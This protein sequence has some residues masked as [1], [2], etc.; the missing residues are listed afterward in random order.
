MLTWQPCWYINLTWFKNKALTVMNFNGNNK[1][2]L[3]GFSDWCCCETLNIRLSDWLISHKRSGRKA[4]FMYSTMC[5]LKTSNIRNVAFVQN[6]S[7][8]ENAL[9]IQSFTVTI[10]KLISPSQLALQ[11]LAEHWGTISMLSLDYRVRE[12]A[13]LEHTLRILWG[14][15]PLKLTLLLHK[16]CWGG[17]G[18]FPGYTR[19]YILTPLLQTF[20][21][22]ML[23]Q[24]LLHTVHTLTLLCPR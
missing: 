1:L 10:K 21:I 4:P 14:M 15:Q 5:T 11:H 24:L 8:L 12:R 7:H 6:N 3:S 9:S 19:S 13:L 22:R 20:V 16:C 17:E 23:S 2:K 18:I